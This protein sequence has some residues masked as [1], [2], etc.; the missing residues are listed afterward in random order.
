MSYWRFPEYVTVGERRA[1][2]DKKLK[3]LKKK[4]PNINPII[5]EGSAI[6]N[7][8][9]GKAWNRNL[10]KY[11][12][13]SN[14]I[15]RGRSYV[16]HGSVLDLQIV[17]GKVSS[18]VQ[19]ST[20]NPY[21]VIIKI[22]R[23]N[24]NN[25]SKIK[26]ACENKLDSLQELLIGKFP[27]SLDEVFTT[28]DKGLFPMPKEINFDCSCPD[29]ASMCKH[30]AATLY[31][32]GARLD[33]DPNLFFTLRKANVNDLVTK[34][35]KD[36]TDKLLKRS[37]K[38]SCRIISD[39]DLSSVFG[40]ELDEPLKST[41][42]SH[43]NPKLKTKNQKKKSTTKNS[44]K[45]VVSK[46]TNSAKIETKNPKTANTKKLKTKN[47]ESKKAST[48]K[49]IKSKTGKIQKNKLTI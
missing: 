14:R 6:A 17:Q 36:K 20:S 45:K 10:E 5:I 30:V 2:A 16:R 24:K 32:I 18:L 1:K 7:S 35:I 42:T 40:I 33:E 26:C 31:G 48:N 44:S 13:Y 29:W 21:S 27:K 46:K 23:I 38:K 8:W 49:K 12:D 37:E 15:G 11:A 39:P 47:D 34:V 28:K 41:K 3:Q 25:W 4:N 43:T 22:K 19:G 9:W